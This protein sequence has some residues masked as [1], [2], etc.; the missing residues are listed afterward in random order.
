MTSAKRR[1]N[2]DDRKRRETRCINSNHEWRWSS[3]SALVWTFIMGMIGMTYI[4]NLHFFRSFLVVQRDLYS[5]NHTVPDQDRTG[6]I[7][8]SSTSSLP[9]SSADSKQEWSDVKLVIYMTTHLSKLHLSFL[10]CWYDALHRLELFRYADLILYT[11]SDH[12]PVPD[13]IRQLL[14][15]RNKM[16]LKYYKNTGYQNGAI[17]AMI[18][19]FLVQNNNDNRTSWFDDYDWVIRLNPDVLIRND[20]WLISTMMNASIDAIVHDCYNRRLYPSSANDDPPARPLILPNPL[21]S[22][23]PST[24][25]FHT[26]FT[27]F[28]PRAI[29]RDLVLSIPVATRP[30]PNPN[31]KNNTT[32]NQTIVWTAEMHLTKALW[33]IYASERFVYLQ[34]GQN[35]VPGRCRLE[36]ID[37]PILHVH[38]LVQSC[39]YYYNATKVG[40]Y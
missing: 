9:S 40:I 14:P 24:P 21:P 18:D 34:G 3:W 12:D 16:I 30:N 27:A 29:R 11:S 31:T 36:G 28:R 8:S 35:S 5:L 39:P 37:S 32:T 38:E 22:N 4:N 6:A 15:V 10:P 1:S 17:Q 25:K 33:N 23:I 7:R 2:H 19:P 13:H 26:D 20:T